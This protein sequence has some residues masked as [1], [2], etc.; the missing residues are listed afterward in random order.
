MKDGPPEF[1]R[2]NAARGHKTMINLLLAEDHPVIRQHLT[3]LL[4]REVGWQVCAETADGL[5]AVRLAKQLKPDVLVT[6]LAMPGLHGL[7]VARRV[8][9]L[10]SQTRIVIVSIHS[11]EQYIR[12]AFRLGVQGYV[13]KDEAGQHLVP[14]INSVLSGDRY[15]SPSLLESSV[16]PTPK[17]QSQPPS[18]VYETLNQMERS[19]LQL[20]AQ[21]YTD[22]EI[23]LHLQL[24]N[25]GASHL[26]SLLM[27]RLGLKS[28]TE[29]AALARKKGLVSGEHEQ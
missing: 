13:R 12:M 25:D 2:T 21:G 14:A 29:L 1:Y 10:S 19:G 4:A 11:D 7:E 27:R 28:S 16:L 9:M 26:R 18:D 6:D 22:A 20:M 8:R 3:R 23:A 5:D 24:T 15:L 17:Q